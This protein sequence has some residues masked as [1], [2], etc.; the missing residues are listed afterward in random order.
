VT[1]PGSAVRGILAR[2]V[3]FPVK[4]LDGRDVG[5][6]HILPSGALEH[7]RRFAIV[8]RDGAFVNGKRDPRVHRIRSS[9]EPAT[10]RLSLRLNGD[11]SFRDFSIDD[12]RAAIESWLGAFF[13]FPVL[14]REGA[15]R[16]FPDD[17][18]A[19]GPTLVAAESLQEVAGW[20][21]GLTE[22]ILAR[23]FRPNLIVRGFPPFGDDGL[24]GPPD[25][26]VRFRIGEV[27]F[28]GV[29]PCQRCAVPTRDPETGS[30]DPHF[31]RTFAVRRRETIP[32]WAPRERFD[33]FYRFTVNTRLA[34]DC[35]GGVI[36]VGD[37]VEAL[38]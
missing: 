20:F 18:D 4:S 24:V 23:R 9:Y 37:P 16:G 21:P 22:A 25:A 13:G 38:G 19:P 34:G 14:V 26:P 15:S 32:S 8:D 7:D 5:E 1:A 3:I 29:N 33:H 12:D 36:R 10:R 28:E 2:I 27:V 31:A 35:P 30:G 17:S 11:A 6:A